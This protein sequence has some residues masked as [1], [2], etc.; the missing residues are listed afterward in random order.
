MFEEILYYISRLDLFFDRVST[1]LQGNI[2]DLYDMET[3]YAR[4]R[5]DV[6]TDDQ[7]YT[8]NEEF[9]AFRGKIWVII[10]R[11]FSIMTIYIFLN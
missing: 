9:V 6:L 1:F 3:D 4:K 7:K 11:P 5:Y 10:K 2:Y 8:A